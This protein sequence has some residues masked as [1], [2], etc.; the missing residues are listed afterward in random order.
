[1]VYLHFVFKLN[2]SSQIV[3]QSWNLYR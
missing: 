2:Q 3:L 1:M